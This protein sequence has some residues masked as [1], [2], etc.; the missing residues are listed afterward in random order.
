MIEHQKGQNT[1]TDQSGTP[2][3][4]TPIYTLIDDMLIEETFE[5]PVVLPKE[6]FVLMTENLDFVEIA[7]EDN[8]LQDEEPSN[9]DASFVSYQMTKNQNGLFSLRAI[10]GLNS[11][12]YK[13][14]GYEI[15]VTTA[16]ETKAFSGT[17]A[18]AYTS[19]N[20]G[21]TTYVAQD[22]FGYEYVGLAMVTGLSA[23]SDYTKIE[24]RTFVT[25][26]DGQVEY[27]KGG[28]LLYEGELDA[29]GYPVLSLISE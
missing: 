7:P 1:K 8:P 3:G 27:G 11:L 5:E 20:G 21:G 13:N 26:L 19:I 6:S 17:S 18:K 29:G 12:G 15:T 10:A 14:F 2:S 4:G 22:T 16:T 28:T 9:P 25:T 23:N 24:I